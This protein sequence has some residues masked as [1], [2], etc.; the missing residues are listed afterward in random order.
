MQAHLRGMRS[1]HQRYMCS[2]RILRYWV[3]MVREMEIDMIVPQHG[4]PFV[5]REHI[6]QFLDWLWHLQCGVDLIEPRIYRCPK[7]RLV[8]A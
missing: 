2:N 5:G 4:A 1:F 7:T 8:V 3:E 6:N